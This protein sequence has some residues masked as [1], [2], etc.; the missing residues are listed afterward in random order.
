MARTGALVGLIALVV[1][2][3]VLAWS[4][5]SAAERRAIVGA[6]RK[7]PAAAGVKRVERVRISTVD[8]R[9]ASAITVPRDKAGNVLARDRWVVRHYPSGWRVV[10]V[11]SDVP[12]C[13]VA[14]AGVR[15][16]LLGSAACFRP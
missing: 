9:F 3:P 6:I 11:G 4:S 16:D 10:F 7:K 13:K 2:A 8:R 12:P 15:R 5:P 1:A 14:P